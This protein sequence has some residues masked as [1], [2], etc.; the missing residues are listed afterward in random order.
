MTRLAAERDA[1]HR[2]LAK[3]RLNANA[4]DDGDDGDD[5]AADRSATHAD[6]SQSERGRSRPAASA[7]SGENDSKRLDDTTASGAS[8]NGVAGGAAASSAGSSPQKEEKAPAAK[9]RPKSAGPVLRGGA[10]AAAARRANVPVP[11]LRPPTAIDDAS[12]R[13]LFLPTAA[14]S[15]RGRRRMGWS[16]HEIGVDAHATRRTRAEV[17]ADN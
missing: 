1:L 6:G 14:N 13:S 8:S 7:A 16:Q 17:A 15:E 9:P 10:A 3:S 5:E 4:N 2:K 11:V 12:D